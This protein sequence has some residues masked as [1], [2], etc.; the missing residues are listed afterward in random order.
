M[1]LKVLYHLKQLQK[2][3][4][5]KDIQVVVNSQFQFNHLNKEIH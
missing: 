5:I 1:K 2:I 3:I 4:E